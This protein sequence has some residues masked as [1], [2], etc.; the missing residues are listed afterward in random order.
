MIKEKVRSDTEQM[1]KVE[2]VLD[3]LNKLFSHCEE[4][5]LVMVNYDREQVMLKGYSLYYYTRWN[6]IRLSTDD[7]SGVTMIEFDHFSQS[8][9]VLSMLEQSLQHYEFISMVDRTEECLK[10]VRGIE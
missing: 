9:S 4:N 7:Y 8:T 1:L 6:S 2:Q 5:N 10:L 3:R